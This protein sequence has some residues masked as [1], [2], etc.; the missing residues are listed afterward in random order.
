[1][2]RV[3]VADGKFNFYDHTKLI[4]S[5]DGLVITIID[6]HYALRTWSLEELMQPAADDMAS[7]DRRRLEVV[8]HKVQYAR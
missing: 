6:K 4:L 3:T 7:K 8:V 5:Q 2:K 1:M